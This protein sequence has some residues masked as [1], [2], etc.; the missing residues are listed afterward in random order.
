[1]VAAALAVLEERGPDGLTMKTLSERLGT[2]VGTIYSYAESKDEL[3]LLVAAEVLSSVAIPEPTDDWE[4]WLRALVWNVRDAFLPYPWMDHGIISR[5]EWT[6]AAAA[7]QGSVADALKT[8][9]FS[10]R[11]RARSSM[12]LYYLA[13]GIL[14]S[15]PL[16]DRAQPRSRSVSSALD[17]VMAGLRAELAA[18]R[19]PR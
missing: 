5:P 8:A 14:L 2:G 7:V 3:M 15:E 17:I 16:V 18:Q 11:S 10:P 13:T 6:E 19:S 4:G 9:G 12:A 1:V